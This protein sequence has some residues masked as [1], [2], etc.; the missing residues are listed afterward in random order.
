MRKVKFF[1]VVMLFGLLLL[2]GCETTKGVAR[3]FTDG[4][5]KD[6]KTFW[7]NLLKADSW[8]KENLW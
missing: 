6:S 4:I 7:E 8:I 2:S 3:G 1:A 5:N